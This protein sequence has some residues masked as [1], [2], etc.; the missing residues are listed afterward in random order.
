MDKASHRERWWV[1]MFNYGKAKLR[2]EWWGGGTLV[3]RQG[4]QRERFC[5]VKF[6]IMHSDNKFH[7]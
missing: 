5:W 3:G 2:V 6:K 7:D 4:S 1:L